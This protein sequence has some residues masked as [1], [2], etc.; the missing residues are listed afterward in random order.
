VKLPSVA[1]RI[2]AADAAF[3]GRIVGARVRPG[4][5][6]DYRFAVDQEV[7][8]TLP[9]EVAA[10]SAA[11]PGGQCGLRVSS[12]EDIGLFLDRAGTGWTTSLCTAVDA[13][14]LLRD[15][16]QPQGTYVRVAIGLVIAAGVILYSLRRLRRRVASERVNGGPPAA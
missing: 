15:A 13:G 16:D 4:G 6:V 12:G 8:G 9:G 5:G 14:V 7:K 1:D 2:A 11:P 10:R 3:V